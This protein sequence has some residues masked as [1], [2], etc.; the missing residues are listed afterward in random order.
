MK[1]KAT[2]EHAANSKDTWRVKSIYMYFV[3][4]GEDEGSYQGNI[5]FENGQDESFKFKIWPGMA[6][7]YIKL[8]SEDI[9][10]GASNLAD[11]LLDSLNKQGLLKTK[12]DGERKD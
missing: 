5:E 8:I 12:E 9:V 4:Y 11:K 3:N 6:N 2:N 10:K 7:T 1:E